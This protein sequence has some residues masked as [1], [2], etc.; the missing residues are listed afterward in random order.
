MSEQ[1]RETPPSGQDLD[2][3]ADPQD[4]PSLVDWDFAKATGRRLVGAG[5]AVG[6]DE[7]A[8]IVGAIRAAAVAAQGPVAETSA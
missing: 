2:P 4:V 3:A 1:H 5:P 7:A 8:E 6:A